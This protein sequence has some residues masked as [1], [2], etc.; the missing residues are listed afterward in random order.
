[1]DVTPAY[2]ISLVCGIKN[3]H[4]PCRLPARHRD[5]PRSGWKAGWQFCLYFMFSFFHFVVLA[6][7]GRGWAVAR[8]PPLLKNCNTC[9]CFS[10]LS[11]GGAGP[12]LHKTYIN[13]FCGGG[14]WGW[15][16]AGP[17]F[18]KIAIRFNVLFGR[19]VLGW[20]RA[21]PSEMYIRVKGS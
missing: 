7:L 11:W 19:G 5:R 15:A 17:P 12:L 1:M 6:R 14:G 16:C 8:P 10:C 9:Q 4:S 3:T 21:S 13:I 2:T 20:R 18:L